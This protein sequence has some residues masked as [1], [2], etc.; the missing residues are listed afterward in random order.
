VRIL[1]M[2]SAASAEIYEGGL[3][4]QAEGVIISDH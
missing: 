3:V 4:A 1:F 2:V